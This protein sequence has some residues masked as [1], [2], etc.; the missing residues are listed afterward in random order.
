MTVTIQVRKSDIQKSLT[1]HY[2][3]PFYLA[4]KRK[5]NHE[6]D[7]VMVEA[8]RGIRLWNSQCPGKKSQILLKSHETLYLSFYMF[9]QAALRVAR[10]TNWRWEVPMRDYEQMVDLYRQVKYTE[11]FSFRAELKRIKVD[12]GFEN[13]L[14]K[15]EK[16]RFMTSGFIEW[17]MKS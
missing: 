9:R 17:E 5:L 1:E 2:W 11:E 4:I 16:K 14:T 13:Y 12:Q 7:L 10:N 3:T 6:K 8:D 15:K